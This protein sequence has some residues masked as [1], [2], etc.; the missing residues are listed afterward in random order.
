MAAAPPGR[1]IVMSLVEERLEAVG[2]VPLAVLPTPLQEAPRLAAHLGLAGLLV[3]RDD[4]TGLAM[5]GNKA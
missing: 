2:R 5:G 3:K 1:E 4:L